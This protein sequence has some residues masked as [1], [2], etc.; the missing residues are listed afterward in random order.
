MTPMIMAVLAG[1]AALLVGI[2]LGFIMRVM[3]SRYQV[4]SAEKSAKRLIAEAK[5][6]SEMIRKE[7]KLELR[8]L[9]NNMK[10]DFE[11]SY[12]SQRKEV[13]QKEKRIMQMQ[14][15]MDRKLN[16][17]DKKEH[18]VQ[19]KEKRIVSKERHLDQELQQVNRHR[20]E[21]KQMLERLAG[22]NREEAKK[23]LLQ[24]IE[25]ETKKEQTVI[26]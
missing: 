21:Q 16:I 23:H 22:M 11:K 15:N 5:S 1:C 8:E 4:G 24:H 13:E 9:K 26:L 3:Y 17:L 14:D 20:E 19:E 10:Q 12:Q 7:G 25:S 2:I 6:E 18:D